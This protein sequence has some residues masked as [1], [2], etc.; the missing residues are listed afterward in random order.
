MSVTIVFVV[1]Q[2]IENEKRLI[3]FL[4]RLQSV[5]LLKC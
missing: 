5:V 2:K 1:Y 4:S 3:K